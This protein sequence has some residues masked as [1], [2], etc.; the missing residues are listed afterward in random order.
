MAQAGDA[1]MEAAEDPDVAHAD[2]LSDWGALREG[3][4][5]DQLPQRLDI[6]QHLSQLD[7]VDVDQELLRRVPTLRKVP[8]RLRPL[9]RQAIASA[10][11]LATQNG[12]PGERITNGETLMRLVTRLVLALP[13]RPPVPDEQET[14][15]ALDSGRFFCDRAC[16]FK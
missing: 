16:A 4:G 3:D 10:C 7:A 13:E 11:V 15:E 2:F 5:G 14:P 6:R 12:V 8:G 1:A 9:V